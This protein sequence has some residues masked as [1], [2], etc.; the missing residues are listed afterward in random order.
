MD[1]TLLEALPTPTLTLPHT[2]FSTFLL[3]ASFLLINAFPMW[4]EIWGGG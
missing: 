2:L 4:Y 1:A 3:F